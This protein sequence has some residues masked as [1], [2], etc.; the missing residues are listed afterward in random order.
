M[1]ASEERR[2]IL[3]RHAKAV[4]KDA[5]DDPDRALT[6][7]GRGDALQCGRWLA[8]S[9]FGADLVVCSPS[10]RT[11]QTWQVMEAQLEEPPPTVYEDRLYNA[12]AD[13][14]IAVL[15]ETSDGVGGL[16]VVGHNPGFHEAATA[17]CGDGPDDL[18]GRL[19]SGFPKAAAAV[20]TFTG[21]WSGLAPGAG[22]LTAFWSPGD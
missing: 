12:T 9:V 22:R 3:V 14:L 13:E 2:I 19:R 6:D 18:V 8:Q 21:P 4:P 1:A 17:L 15:K 16:L 11:R 20:L 10:R 7:R 5:A